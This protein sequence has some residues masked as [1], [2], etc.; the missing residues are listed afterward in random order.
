MP[1][2]F[3]FRSLTSRRS[4]SPAMSS[5]SP[6]AFGLHKLMSQPSRG[7]LTL[8]VMTAM[9]FSAVVVAFLAMPKIKSVA[10]DDFHVQ[11]RKR[12]EESVQYLLEEDEKERKARGEDVETGE[13]FPKYL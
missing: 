2:P 8:P 3:A 11:Y 13:G 1:L 12:W 7:A 9:T 10:Q 5:R 6:P 4:I